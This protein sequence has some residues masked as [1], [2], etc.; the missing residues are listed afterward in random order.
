MR[1]PWRAGFPLLLVA[2]D[3][4]PIEGVGHFL[5][6]ERPQEFNAALARVIASIEASGVR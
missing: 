1:S 5:Q 3:V 4:V 2:L 6:L